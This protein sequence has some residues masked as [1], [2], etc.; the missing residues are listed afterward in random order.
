MRN[1]DYYF[2]I[3]TNKGCTTLYP[4][5]TNDLSVRLHQHRFGEMEGFTKRYHLNC[6]VWFEHFRDVNNA[7]ACEKKL[8]GWRRSRK[9]ALVEEKNPR[10]MDLSENWEQQPKIDRAWKPEEMIGDS[11]LRSE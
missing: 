11:S 1:H 7:I 10:W 8:K 2:Y 4:G 3:L 5:V 9:I 6:L